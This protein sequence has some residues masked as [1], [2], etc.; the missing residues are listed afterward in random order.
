MEY[1]VRGPGGNVNAIL[2]RAMKWARQ[3]WGDAWKEKWEKI[4][5]DAQSGDYDHALDVVEKAFNGSIKFV[6]RDE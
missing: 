4:L 3:C 2:G 6:G 1:D 5:K